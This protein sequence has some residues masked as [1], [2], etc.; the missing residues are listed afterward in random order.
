MNNK[1]KSYIIMIIFFLSILVPFVYKTNQGVTSNSNTEDFNLSDFNR[2]NKVFENITHIQKGCFVNN[3]NPSLNEF[4]QLYLPNHHLSYAKM[5]FDNI[6]AINYTKDIETEFSD[7][8][9]SSK[10]GSIYI[11]Q[12]F[13]VR[14]SQY[15]NNVSIL[16]QDINNR[17]L[18]TE[19][20]SW[21][22]A[23]VNCLNDGKG[24]PNPNATLGKVQK[25]HP[26]KIYPIWLTFNFKSSKNGPVYLNITET[27]YTT[28]NGIIKYWF[29]FRVKIP[30]DD[31]YNGGG[32]KYLYFNRDG[33]DESDEGEGEIF[34]QSPDF[35]FDNYTI[36][37][38]FSTTEEEGT[39]LEGNQSSFVEHN[40]GDQYIISN[41]SNKVKFI[42]QFNLKDLRNY[43]GTYQ[44]LYN[45]AYGLFGL[46][47]IDWWFNHYKKLF[48]IEI[49]LA[50]NVSNPENIED[51]TLYAWNYKEPIIFGSWQNISHFFNLKNNN[52]ELMTYEIREPDEKF[53]FLQWIDSTD[54][55]KLR[56]MFEYFGNGTSSFNVTVDKLTIEI[57]EI[58]QLN[59]IQKHD[60][61]IEE[62]IFPT[63]L[64]MENDT[65]N[66]ESDYTLNKLYE[67]DNDYLI[68][69][70]KSNNLT[71]EFTFN[72]LPEYNDYFNDINFYDWLVKYPYP[73]LPKAEI[74]ISSN[75]SITNQDNLT[76][77]VLEFYKGNMSTGIFE[78]AFD[79]FFPNQTWIPLSENKTYAHSNEEMIIT[80]LDPSFTW[81]F[82]QLL[83]ESADNLFRMRLRYNSDTI[84]GYNITIDE[85]SFH[86]Y[87]QNLISSDITSKIG[88]G[89]DKNDIT[90]QYLGMQNNGKLVVNDGGNKG[91]WE[92]NI[93]NGV[94]ESGNYQFNVTSIWP[95]FAF[96]VNGTYE[97]YKI[98]PEIQFLT[99]FNPEYMAGTQFFTVNVTGDNGTAISNLKIYF[100]VMDSSNFMV[101][102]FS[103]ITDENGI[104]SIYL[105]L[106]N[107]GTD[108]S[109][110]VQCAEDDVYTISET[111]S[112][113]FR[114]VNGLTMFL[115]GLLLL[116]PAFII[117]LVGISIYIVVRY[118]K[119]E[120]LRQ[121]WE[122]DT[123]LFQDLLNLSYIMII[124]KDVG[125]SIY[126]KQISSEKLDTDLIGGF[127]HAI[128]S[129]KSEFKTSRKEQ[130]SKGFE[131]NYYDFNIIISDGQYIR[132]ALISENSLSEA[133]KEKQNLFT[134]EFETRF[135][136]ELKLFDGDITQFKRA[137]GLIEE[138]F[139]ISLLYPLKLNENANYSNLDSIEKDLVKIA[140]ELILE[141]G[142]FYVSNL[143]NFGIMVKA[144]PRNKIISKIMSL[145]A[146][147]IFSSTNLSAPSS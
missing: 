84:E 127:L 132:V 99:I 86:L 37:H 5:N 1:N 44:D 60:P 100:Q 3:K 25:P 98:K 119:L 38:V 92:D 54:N 17:T 41:E 10:N 63:S 113:R 72:V 131:M 128:S 122:R 47:L 64:L 141:N 118:R 139:D 129:F 53:D 80:E 26:I 133:F 110:R 126:S 43:D 58:E 19:E 125:V 27:N 109:I 9:K 82:L 106:K 11:Y 68:A 108:F 107:V 76:H 4:P 87:L 32:P 89:V 93:F 105:D 33:V 134:Q 57:G 69:Q 28:S 75:V 36:N 111:Y 24:T 85:I 14:M 97:I 22:V 121:E 79:T 124:H 117:I 140:E 136:R 65:I 91:Y 30:P 120:R 55:N 45:E 21:E 144:E 115:D 71:S 48:K 18:F 104:A 88:F 95:F 77:A 135:H 56:F 16:I 94:F 137:D 90:P 66:E 101:D 50:L 52:S 34:C 112:S 147:G 20:N 142:H 49:S 8:V 13:Y 59:E 7:S 35:I 70:A 145:K 39:L 102:Q 29:A 81:I 51:C 61:M 15:I 40:D 2:E 96:D 42:T 67:N 146:Q 123:E 78:E 23:I 74:R 46:G 12:K 62:L 6:T 103:T 83:N 138:F 31:S 130:L 114:V 143:L 116:S 73:Y